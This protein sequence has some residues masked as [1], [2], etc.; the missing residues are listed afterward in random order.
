M[1]RTP[2]ARRR[3]G[4]PRRWLPHRTTSP[5]GSRFTAARPACAIRSTVSS[6]RAGSVRCIWRRASADRRLCRRRCASRSVEHRRM[7]ARSILRAAAARS[8]ARD[9]DLRH[10]S[11]A[12]AKRAGLLL[13]RTRICAAWRSERL[14]RAQHAHVGRVHRAPRNCRHPAGARETAS[15][16]AAPP[17][18]HA[19]ERLRLR[20]PASEAWRLRHRPAAK[21]PARRDRA[22]AE[23]PDGAER[24]LRRRGAQVAGTR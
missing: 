9:P 12:G 6:D 3:E 18:P 1:R 15:G 16:P 13:S 24:H 4:Q 14:S 19:V 20:R 22:H 11:L 17:R 7:A 2:R 5:R 10:V 8:S 23:S 21:R